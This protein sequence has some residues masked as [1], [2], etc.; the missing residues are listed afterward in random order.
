MP[1]DEDLSPG[2]TEYTE[3]MHGQRKYASEPGAVVLSSDADGGDDDVDEEVL[4][5]SLA[6][7]PDTNDLPCGDAKAIRGLRLRAQRNARPPK[8]TQENT[9]FEPNIAD[10]AGERCWGATGGN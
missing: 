6:M 10:I 2:T 1:C 7:V 8:R 3:S 5:E 9:E 4:L